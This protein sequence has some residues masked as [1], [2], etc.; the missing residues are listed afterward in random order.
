MKTLKPMLPFLIVI[1][2]CFYLLPLLIQDTGSGMLILL[3]VT[4]LLCF[5]CSLLYG[6]KKAF[7]P[8]YALIVAL[9]F[10]P[11]IFIFYNSS[12]WIYAPAYGAIALLGGAAGSHIGKGGK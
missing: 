9:L 10:V 5:V 6:T 12:A 1:L 11:A 4:P 8:L 7:S 3:I 2:A